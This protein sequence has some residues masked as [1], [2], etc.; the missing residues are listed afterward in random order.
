MANNRVL[1]KMV[2]FDMCFLFSRMGRLVEI[3]SSKLDF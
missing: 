1:I 2:V 3:L